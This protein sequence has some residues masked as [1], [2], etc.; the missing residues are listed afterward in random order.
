MASFFILLALA[1]DTAAGFLPGGP[2]LTLDFG[3]EWSDF[4]EDETIV[5]VDFDCEWL[6]FDEDETMREC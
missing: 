4:D 5:C 2:I 1:N 3:C 6:D